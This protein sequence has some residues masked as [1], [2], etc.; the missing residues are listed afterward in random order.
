M[1]DFANNH[2]LIA[3]AGFALVVISIDCQV[4]NLFRFLA[5]E[6]PGDTPDNRPCATVTAKSSPASSSQ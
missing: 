4:G 5:R 6:K 2:P 3:L 1:I